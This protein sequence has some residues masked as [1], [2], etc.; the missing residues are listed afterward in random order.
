M[1][2]LEWEKTFYHMCNALSSVTWGE[3]GK[4]GALHMLEHV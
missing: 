3:R 4:E 2:M 1:W